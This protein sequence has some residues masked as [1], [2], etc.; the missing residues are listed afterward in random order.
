MVALSS[1]IPQDFPGFIDTN[2]MPTEGDES[3]QIAI[4]KP[5]P[6]YNNELRSCFHDDMIRFTKLIKIR[7]GYQIECRTLEST[8]P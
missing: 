5:H 8:R 2:D 6:V 1:G 7:F 4:F 3:I